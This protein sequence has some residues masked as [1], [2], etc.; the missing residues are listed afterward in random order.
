MHF[1]CLWLRNLQ[2]CSIVFAPTHPPSKHSFSGLQPVAGFGFGVPAAAA[3]PTAP[4]DDAAAAAGAAAATPAGG[5]GFSASAAEPSL[6]GQLDSDV[7]QALRRLAKKD[8]TTKL[9]ALQA[10]REMAA[11]SGGGG[12]GTSGGS[13]GDNGGSSGDN[14]GGGSGGGAKPADALAAALQPWAYYF[15]RLM[16]D[17][18][19]T[20]RSEACA[21]MGALAAAVG[22]RLAP[23]LKALL[24]PW[25][26]A[27]FDPYADVAAAAR[28]SLAAAFPGAKQ[29]AALAFCRCASLLRARARCCC[30]CACMY[31]YGPGVSPKYQPINNVHPA[32][33]ITKR[34]PRFEQ[35]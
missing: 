19:K 16:M 30:Y 1:V 26:L 29:A 12:G 14:G 27:Q 25:W 34:T 10:L 7:A 35:I 31:A 8:A 32:P 22:K 5:G 9:K 4:A 11:G 18:A 20:V 21:A 17:P 24:P 13:S 3:A 6:P 15:R 28:R 23:H 33:C 2:V